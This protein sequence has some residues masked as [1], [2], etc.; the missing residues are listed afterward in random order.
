MVERIL[1]PTDGSET[2]QA[3]IRFAKDIALAENAE[4]VVL[5]VVQAG[6]Y[7]DTAQLD[8]APLLE[9]DV[10]KNVEQEV[11]QL[12]AEGVS[13]TGMTVVG[14]QVHSVIADKVADL[15]IDLIVMGTHGRT[16]LSRAVIGSVA[17]KVVRHTAVPV[18]LVPKR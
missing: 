15:G 3:A 5:G 17:D 10:R 8:V 7:G 18:V 9:P 4:V 2:A 13:A 6:V 14:D 12:T 16:G 1:T 11:A